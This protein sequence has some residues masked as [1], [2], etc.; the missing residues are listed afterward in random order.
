MTKSKFDLN[1]VLRRG[2]RFLL[3]G[4]C[5]E[6]VDIARK[7]IEVYPSNFDAQILLAKAYLQQNH[8]EQ[9]VHHLQRAITLQP[10]SRDVIA[11]YKNLFVRLFDARQ[12]ELLAQA[13]RSLLKIDPNDGSA[14][15]YLGVSCIE[16]GQFTDAYEAESNAV[17]L[18]PLN[19]SFLCNLGNVLISIDRYAEAIRVLLKAIELRPLH[20]HAFN[21]L[22]NAYRKVDKIEDAIKCY[23]RAIEIS[24]GHAFVYNNLAVG[25]LSNQQYQSAIETCYQGLAL[26]PDLYEIYPTI[27]DALRHAGRLQ[28]AIE[29]CEKSQSFC[30]QIPQFWGAYGHT[31]RESA[32]I[33]AAIEAYTRGISLLTNTDSSYKRQMYTHLLFCL[34]YHPD[35]SAELIYS[36]YKEFDELFCLK[37]RN[38]WR[39]F[40]ND[41]QI[42]KRLKVGYLSHVFYNQVCRYFFIPLLENHNRANVEVFAYSNTKQHDEYTEQYKNM[43]DH[44]V[45][46]NELTDDEL[47]ERI[48]SDG[49]DIL[50]DVAGH[51]ANNRLDVFARKPAPVS[52]HWLEYGY[53]TGL[54]AI[55]YYLTDQ[56]CNIG[57][58][59]HLFSEKVWPLEGAFNSYR[60]PE[61]TPEVT[62]LPC[63]KTGVITFGTLSRSL[64]IN[65]R[66]IRVW[67]SIL[68]AMPNSRL[69]INSGDFRDPKSQEEMANRFVRLG[70]DRSRLD[71]GYTSPSFEVLKEIDI[72]LDCFP[73]N[74]GTTLLESLYMGVPYITL[75]DRP[76]VGR[77]GAGSLAAV[78]HPEWI[79]LSEM[80][81]AQK[82]ITLAHDIDGLIKIRATLRDQMKRSAAMD[83]QGFARSVENAYRQ[84]WTIFCQEN[85][86]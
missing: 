62:S 26:Q 56:I 43:V 8:F 65:H 31:L 83:E 71:V 75:F 84:M 80:E 41:R 78:G 29:T 85:P 32:H 51:T 9:G 46:T 76:S 47:S 66:V 59:H 42:G 14:W 74:S 18:D 44:W 53:T 54:S 39:P 3:A 15:D 61:G 52:L 20:F 1:S 7:I 58:P 37:Y 79:A 68:D 60:A 30:E 33:N 5:E 77:L 19:A 16:L 21:N 36:A 38:Q 23:Q 82:A 45:D 48:R 73:H 22:G 72:G 35:M 70:I 17:K 2:Q 11:I 49:I 34:N 28:E 27:I 40:T 55:D 10:K 63:L 50:V 6:V 25:Y 81:Y 57:D 64:R 86:L 67:A 24:P 13:S 12:F 4:Q 69:V